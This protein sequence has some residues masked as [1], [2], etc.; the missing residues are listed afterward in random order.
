MELN[1]QVRDMLI[2]ENNR[3]MIPVQASITIHHTD[4]RKILDFVKPESFDF[5][6]T[7]PPFYDIE[8]YGDEPTQLGKSTTYSDFISALQKVARNCF[9]ALKP[10]KY[11]AWEVNDFRRKGKFHVYHNDTINIFKNVG[12]TI[13][14]VII[15]DYGNSF[16]A[17]FLSDVEH[18]KI[19]PKQHSYI[20]V[21]HKPND[22]ITHK[23][24]RQETRQ[25]LLNEL[26]ENGD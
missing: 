3:S 2:E 7:S 9:I 1:Y 4:S 12:F 10:D 25:K 5:C 13:H 11:I 26:G 23:A 22:I 15:V 21:G 24:N 18:N 8:Y 17:S 19:M 20:I 16:L 6:I 14:D